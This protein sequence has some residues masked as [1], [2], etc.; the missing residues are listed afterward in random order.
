M[1]SK[2]IWSLTRRVF[3][4]ASIAMRVLMHRSW[5]FPHNAGTSTPISASLLRRAFRLHLLPVPPRPPPL[6]FPFAG[7]ELPVLEVVPP[8]LPARSSSAAALPALAAM[9]PVTPL[10]VPVALGVA[11]LAGPWDGVENTPPEMAQERSDE[12]SRA[13]TAPGE[14]VSF[15]GASSSLSPSSP[16]LRSTE[17][18]VGASRVVSRYRQDGGVFSMPFVVMSRVCLVAWMTIYE[19]RPRGTVPRSAYSLKTITD[20]IV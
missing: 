9:D 19:M 18:C 15:C 10:L 7:E 16:R 12:Y 20:N 1:V 3:T 4:F 8:V 14:S 5:M 11:L 13:R 6:A 2:R 17:R